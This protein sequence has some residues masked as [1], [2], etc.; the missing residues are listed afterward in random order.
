MEAL[1]TVGSNVK[2]TKQT[3]TPYIKPE[4]EIKNPQRMWFQFW[5]S[6]K[7]TIPECWRLKY[8]IA[9]KISPMHET[10]GDEFLDCL[11]YQK[12]KCIPPT[13]LIDFECEYFECKLHKNKGKSC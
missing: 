5:K 8:D 10:I 7:I 2:I 3:A 1:K 4:H 6:K 9:Y 13:W 12:N 11:F